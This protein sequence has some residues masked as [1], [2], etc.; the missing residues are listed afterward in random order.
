MLATQAKNQIS[1]H[2][3]KAIVLYE[4]V[5]EKSVDIA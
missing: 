2:S 1:H 4:Y 3:Q 5:A